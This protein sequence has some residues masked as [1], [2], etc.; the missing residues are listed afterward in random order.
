MGQ[1]PNPASEHPTGITNVKNWTFLNYDWE[2]LIDYFF[3]LNNVKVN[4]KYV[5]Y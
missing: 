1:H 4:V 5:S 2:F 3:I